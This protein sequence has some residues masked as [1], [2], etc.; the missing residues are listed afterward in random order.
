MD[1]IPGR[2]FLI[3]IQNGLFLILI[4]DKRPKPVIT[5]MGVFSDIK[6]RA[7]QDGKNQ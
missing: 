1:V 2:P 5:W 6:S 4:E 7:T 3:D